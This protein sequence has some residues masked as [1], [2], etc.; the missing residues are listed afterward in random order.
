MYLYYE[1]YF[2]H[3]N[4]GKKSQV[5]VVNRSVPGSTS[6]GRSG[7]RNSFILEREKH[8]FLCFPVSQGTNPVTCK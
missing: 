2:H 4:Y 3:I 6:R 5:Q 7:L 8:P 1:I